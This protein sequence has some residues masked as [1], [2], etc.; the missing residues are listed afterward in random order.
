MNHQSSLLIRRL[1]YGLVL[2]VVIYAAFAMIGETDQLLAHL[3]RVPWYVIAGACGL[4]VLNYGLRFL[5]WHLYLHLIDISIPRRSSLLIFVAGLVM[6]ISPGKVGEVVKSA[7]L[8]RSHDISV[9]RSAPVVFAERLTDLL[10]LFLLAAVGIVVFQYGIVAFGLIFC[11]LLGAT[12][13]LQVPALVHGVLD[14]LEHLPLIG[15]FRSDL[16]R[17]YLSTRTLLGWR[18]LAAASLLS[19]AAWSLEA[20][21]LAWLLHH[22]GALWPMLFEAFFVYSVSTLLGAL[23]FLPGGLGVTEGSMTGLLLWLDVFD[24]LSAALAAT[25]LIRFT[26]LWFGVIVGL[27]AFLLYELRQRNTNP[28]L[29]DDGGEPR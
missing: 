15:G 20:I 24:D 23:S 5:R 8:K 13:L 29:P 16:E 18:P 22:L 1:I 11:A 19:A 28:D 7:L 4:S 10:G 3:G 27:L 14:R 6:A 2:A 12:A 17:A 21:A 26:T 25:Y 9:A